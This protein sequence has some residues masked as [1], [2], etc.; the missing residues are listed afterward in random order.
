MGKG[1]VSLDETCV[2]GRPLNFVKDG[3]A[4]CGQPT[5]ESLDK[6]DHAVL[7]DFYNSMA[8]MGI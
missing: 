2:C 5:C 3:K 7:Q 1:K 4:I 8:W 6:S